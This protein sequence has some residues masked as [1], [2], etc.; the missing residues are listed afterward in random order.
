MIDFHSIEGTKPLVASITTHLFKGVRKRLRFSYERLPAPDVRASANGG[1]IVEWNFQP[2]P[3][4]GENGLSVHSPKPRFVVLVAEDGIVS[5][6]LE[7]GKCS[8]CTGVGMREELVN[9]EVFIA[10]L[11]DSL[12]VVYSSMRR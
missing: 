2:D 11:L 1:L 3:S 4:L 10:T 7:F 5:Y 12:Y 9:V 8:K 6:S